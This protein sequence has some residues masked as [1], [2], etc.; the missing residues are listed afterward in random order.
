MHL[1]GRGS[2]PLPINE[3]SEGRLG[4]SVALA[5]NQVAGYA[6]QGCA[7]D[8][9]ASQFLG[10]HSFRVVP[11]MVVAAVVPVMILVVFVVFLISPDETWCGD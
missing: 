10:V 8:A 3:A 11:V 2:W 9:N 4:R 1:A 7:S 6:E 5:Q